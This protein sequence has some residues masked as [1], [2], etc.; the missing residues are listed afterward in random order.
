MTT[1]RDGTEGEKIEARAGLADVF[2]QRGMLEEAADLVAANVKAGSKD[3]ETYRWLARLYR[4]QGQEDLAARAAAEAA[5]LRG[6]Q[7]VL[8]PRS[9]LIARPAPTDAL[10]TEI[11]RYV[12]A[13][14]RVVSQTATTAQLVKPRQFNAAA[15]ILWFLLFA[16]GLLL[17]L[18]YYMG[19][20]D[21]MVYLT[22]GPDGRVLT[23]SSNPNGRSSLDGKWTCDSC[24]HLNHSARLVCKRPSCRAARPTV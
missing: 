18:L 6:Y 13:G 5:V 2:E 3:S 19:Q 4:A 11:R 14:F 21:E 17:Y 12:G 20:R 1:L 9:E 22:I 8:A 10:D 15:A 7:P 16:V 24:G 23:R